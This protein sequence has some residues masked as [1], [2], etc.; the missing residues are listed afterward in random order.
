[1]TT[2]KA[3]VSFDVD[4]LAFEKTIDEPWGVTIPLNDSSDFITYY[5]DG[6]CYLLHEHDDCMCL[7]TVDP[8]YRE[9]IKLEIEKVLEG[10][11]Y[12]T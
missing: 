5:W 8:S 7:N 3:F 1:M 4:K 6:A 11:T 10:D 9:I 12:E 2:G